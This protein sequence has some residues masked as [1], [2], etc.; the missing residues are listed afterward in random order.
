MEELQIKLNN[1]SSVATASS[2]DFDNS[3]NNENISLV[4]TSSGIVIKRNGSV[5]GNVYYE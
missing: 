4:V 1:G 2:S 3:Q 5:L